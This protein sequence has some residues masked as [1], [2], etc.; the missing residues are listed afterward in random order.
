[1]LVH[2][3]RRCTADERD[4]LRRVFSVA[5]EHRTERDVEWVF[6]LFQHHGSIDFA[7]AGLRQVVRAAQDEF[8]VAY[9]DAP[10]AADR[11]VIRRLIPFL[12]DRAV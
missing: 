4:R 11:D 3:L 12:G 5:R 6:R 1:M 10:G 9:R 2:A 7:R 8:D